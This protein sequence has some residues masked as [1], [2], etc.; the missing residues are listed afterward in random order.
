MGPAA[1]YGRQRGGPPAYG[2]TAGALDGLSIASFSG[3]LPQLGPPQYAQFPQ[4][5]P[6]FT[7]PGHNAGSYYGGG[8]SV[9]QRVPTIPAVRPPLGNSFSYPNQYA[10]SGAGYGTNGNMQESPYNI[11]SPPSAKGPAFFTPD[12]QDFDQRSLTWGNSML[13][14]QQAQTGPQSPGQ[15]P[16]FDRN[17]MSA[18]N[19][20][21]LGLS[22]NLAIQEIDLIDLK[23]M[24]TFAKN[25]PFVSAACGKW[26][27]S[28]EVKSLFSALSCTW[29]RNELFVF[30]TWTGNSKCRR[31]RL[32]DQTQLEVEL[33]ERR[34]PAPDRD[35]QEGRH[36]QREL[37]QRRPA[38]RNIR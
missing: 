8:G 31:H 26:T 30:C 11:F 20:R 10:A 3:Q 2:N 14:Q 17:L 24:H 15:M 33:Q 16:I 25:C 37:L 13:L 35:Q 12:G 9:S 27:A 28:T 5:T 29:N 19:A 32:L 23:P 6:M 22:F 18:E 7:P 1:P 34:Q 36:G 38:E 4:P 21:K